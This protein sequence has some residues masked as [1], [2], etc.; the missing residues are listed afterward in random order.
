MADSGFELTKHHGLGNDFLIALAP[1]QPIGS[2]EAKRW[3]DRRTGIGA[4]GLIVAQPVQS[5]GSDSHRWSMVLW[6][7]D[8]SRAEISGNGIRCL[9]QAIGLRQA[10]EAPVPDGAEII[11]DTDAGPRTLVLFPAGGDTW[12]VRA[13]MGRVSDGP[14]P[15]PSWEAVGL[16]PSHQQGV[17]VGNP[18]IVAIVSRDEFDRADPSEV[19]PVIEAGYPGGINVHVVTV[20]GPN[21]L[22]LKVWERGVGVTQACGS[23][24]CAGAWAAHRLGLVDGGGP[25]K[26]IQVSMPGG[27]AS[28]EVA[29]DPDDNTVFLIGPA[30]YI[31]SI[32]IA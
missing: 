14:Q 15:S 7:A 1:A 13:E 18:H 3:C 5:D 30:T 10:E 26:Q 29:N 32:C 22:A 11:I 24:A 17:D 6:N 2:P 8:G 23:G 27:S 25:E 20:D 19:G 9:G 16:H 21:E 12:Q 31:G 28:V 4:D